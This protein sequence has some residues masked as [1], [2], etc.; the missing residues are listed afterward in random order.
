MLIFT[1]LDDT[2][3]KTTRKMGSLE[4]CSVGAC[5][6]DQNP[7]SYIDPSRQLLINTLLDNNTVIP[8]TA[9][10]F[11]AMSRV[12]LNFKH[13]KII[14][15][16]GTILNSDNSINKEWHSLML[17][18]L[19]IHDY[20]KAIN[21]LKEVLSKNLEKNY[22]IIERSENEVFIFL[23]LRNSNLDLQENYALKDNIDQF[24]KITDLSHLFYMYVT[25]RDVTIIPTFIKKE[26][27]VAFIKKSYNTACIGMGDHLNDLPFMKLC[28]FTLFPND[29][30]IAQQLYGN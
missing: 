5:D 22:K 3:M 1:D 6:V 9:R 18:Q 21:L 26:N 17:N 2:L 27:A 12:Q 23:N 24:F 20:Y 28:D 25:D 4:S 7:S 15:F 13:E 14:N 11:I 30:L 16:G 19:L 10:S 8:V 29:S